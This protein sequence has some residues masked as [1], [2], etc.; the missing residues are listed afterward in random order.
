MPYLQLDV[1]AYYPLEKKRRVAQRLG[2]HYAEVMQ[3]TPDLV[4]VTFRELGEGGVWHCG[5]EAATPSAVLMCEIRRGRPPEQRARLG[6]TLVKALVEELGLDPLHLAIEFTQHAGDE[7]YLSG[8]VDGVL[9]G[10]LGRDWTPGETSQP[11][12]E[13]LVAEKRASKSE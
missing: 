12:M 3:T 10:S 1:P 13:Q 5:K 7:I 6:E 8:M 9:Q 11:L 4:N 2:R